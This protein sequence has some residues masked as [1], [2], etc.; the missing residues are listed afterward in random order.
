MKEKTPLKN[1]TEKPTKEQ[2]KKLKKSPTP[3]EKP[4]FPFEPEKEETT[5]EE[6]STE[7]SPPGSEEEEADSQYLEEICGNLWF[8]LYQLGGILKKGF[9]PLTDDVRK[10]L[11]PPSARM[12]VKYHVETFLKDEFLLLGILG[13]D[14]S[15][16]LMVKKKDDKDD[17]REKG[18]GKDDPQ[19]Q[20][21]I[22]L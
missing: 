15:K 12:A 17:N 18:K 7:P 6:S 16:R 5:K 2:L 9:E 8:V 21:D 22:N 20:P 11:E 4:P 19:S 1:P 10:L 13:I 14:I 3:E